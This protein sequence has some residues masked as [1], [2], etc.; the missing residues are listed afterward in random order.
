MKLGGVVLALLCSS[1]AAAFDYCPAGSNEGRDIP[2]DKL[3]WGDGGD[4]R[5]CARG[6]TYIDEYC[7]S[8]CDTRCEE[9][10]YIYL[11]S[12]CCGVDVAPEL[13]GGG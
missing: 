9:G 5:T 8:S 11:I 12:R 6:Q 13:C 7:C 3:I 1:A 2:G 10:C 4:D